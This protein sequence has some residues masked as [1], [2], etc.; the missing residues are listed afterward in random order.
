MKVIFFLLWLTFYCLVSS[1]QESVPI[2][3]KQL[4]PNRELTNFLRLD[5]L[6]Q[7]KPNVNYELILSHGNWYAIGDG[8]GQVFISEN[9]N[10][11]RIDKTRLEGYH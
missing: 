2:R 10:W 11:K 1:A 9:G 7:T 5:S 6:Q 8:D 4:K 3:L